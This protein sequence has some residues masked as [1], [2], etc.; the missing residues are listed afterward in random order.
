MT[1]DLRAHDRV[2]IACSSGEDSAATLLAVLDGSSPQQRR[3]TQPSANPLGQ[4]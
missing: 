2:L 4:G 3:E 1:S